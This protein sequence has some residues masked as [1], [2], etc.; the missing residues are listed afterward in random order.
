LVILLNK[1]RNSVI[2]MRC[3]HLQ[4]IHLQIVCKINSWFSYLENLTQKNQ[5]DLRNGWLLRKVWRS[6]FFLFEKCAMWKNAGAIH[7]IFIIKI[8]TMD[9]ASIIVTDIKTNRTCFIHY[10][11]Y[12]HSFYSNPIYILSLQNWPY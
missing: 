6:P 12:I 3:I 10:L 1:L 8:R 11:H 7:H 2:Q 5:N 9:S 4:C